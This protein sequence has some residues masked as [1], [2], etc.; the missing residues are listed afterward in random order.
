MTELQH[1]T[2][3]QF[4][5]ATVPTHPEGDPCATCEPK[6]ELT[7]EEESILANLRDIKARIRPIGTRMKEIEENRISSTEHGLSEE[8]ESEWN[9]L[10]SSLERFRAEWDEWQVKLEAAIERKLIMLGHREPS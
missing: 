6:T 2:Q 3:E 1:G 9:E 10:F 7:R 4:G 8:E 5:C